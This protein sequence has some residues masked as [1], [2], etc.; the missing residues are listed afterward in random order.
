[1]FKLLESNLK[2]AMV[3]VLKELMKIVDNMCQQMGN[4]SRKIETIK[5]K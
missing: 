1:M 4:F 3:T 2:V 5:G